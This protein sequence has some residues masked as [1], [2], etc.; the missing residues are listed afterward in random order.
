MGTTYNI[1]Y[2]KQTDWNPAPTI[3][4]ILHQINQAVSTYIPD[5][6]ISV[7]NLD[8]AAVNYDNA[9]S[10]L[11]YKMQ[12]DSHFVNN[13]RIS[14]DMYKLTNGFFDPTIMPLVNF[15]GFG[16]EEKK[17]VT[18][19]DSSKVQELSQ[20]VDFSHWQLSVEDDTMLIKK[21]RNS[22][23]DFSAVAK[24]Y[25][26]DILSQNLGI[27]GITDFMVEIGGEVYCK[28]RNNKSLPWSIGLSKPEI[29]AGIREFEAI[30]K[31]NDEA[32]ASSGNYRNYYEVNG[33]LYGHEINPKT[34]YPEINA[35]LGVTTVTSN[36]AKA[37]ALATAFMVM[38]LER[39]KNWLN[40][41]DNIQAILFYRENDA[42][43]GRW[44]T[45]DIA[46]KVSFIDYDSSY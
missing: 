12:V 23:L 17:P 38:G 32:M 39:S 33:S 4:S 10:I 44:M 13:F 11:I 35:L 20:L 16:Y 5:S 22:Q 27:H 6:D 46:S 19:V 24:G 21:P 28:G 40:S 43:I 29:T 7:I 15:W 26:V 2:I 25:A 30:I 42:G 45:Q 1:S 41:K 8:T 3:D 14:Q 9:D 36:C 34:G 37:D 31:L 18:V